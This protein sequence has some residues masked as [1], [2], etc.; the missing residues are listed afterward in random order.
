[1]DLSFTA[2]VEKQFDEIAEGAKSWS[3][4]IRDF[5]SPFHEK[6]EYTLENAERA[7]GERV[8]GK[9]PKTGEPVVA[10]IGKFGAMIQIG[11]GEDDVKPRFA[12]LQ[13]GMSLGSVTFEEAMKLFDF[14]KTVGQYEG[15]EVVVA[16]GRFGPY[17]KFKEMY[18]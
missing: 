12:G 3:Q 5:Y 4:M 7:K 2:S 11:D 13:N 18:Y 6:V 10:R 8:L 16:Q 15:E 1:M 17:V 14:P 9:D